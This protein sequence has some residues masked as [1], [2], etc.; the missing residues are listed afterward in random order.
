[1]ILVLFRLSS[2]TSVHKQLDSPTIVMFL[3]SPQRHK[4]SMHLRHFSYFCWKHLVIVIH[5]ETHYIW[6]WSCDNNTWLRSREERKQCLSQRKNLSFPSFALLT[7]GRMWACHV[8]T[9]IH[10]CTGMLAHSWVVQRSMLLLH[11]GYTFLQLFWTPL[12]SMML[13]YTYVL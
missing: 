9:G 4:M 7:H 3:P 5:I 8:C 12:F 6:L 10:T 11:K 1:M 13:N 2:E